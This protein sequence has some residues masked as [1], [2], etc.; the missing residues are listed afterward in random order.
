M[1]RRLLAGMALIGAMLASG[2]TSL[3]SSTLDAFRL[4][5]RNQASVSA[6]QV[7][8][9]RFPQAQLQAPSLDAVLVLG[10]VDAGRQ[11]W[12][13][14]KHAIFWM[15]A[16]GLVT[17]MSGMGRRIESHIIGT[18]PFDDLTAVRDTVEFK[19]TYDTIPDYQFG[20]E[21][22]STLK[23]NREE[24][25]RILDRRMRLVRFDERVDGPGFTLKNTYWADPASG[26]IWKS[27]QHLAPDYAIEVTQL[28]PY[29]S[30]KD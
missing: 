7:A 5:G 21:A 18:S 17:G 12:Y 22:V 1:T 4:V 20:V 11:V 15:D 29:R 10:Y 8:A 19:R 6:E 27:R 23:R 2:C 9:N 30:T 25:V 3:S 24:S 13:A 16:R 28:K 26:F 14:G